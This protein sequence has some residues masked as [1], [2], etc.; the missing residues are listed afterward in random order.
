MTPKNKLFDVAFGSIYEDETGEYILYIS[1]CG[2]GV[3]N[4]ELKSK[5]EEIEPIT[6]QHPTIRKWVTRE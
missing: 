1:S 5:L 6:K 4:S 3:I 2:G